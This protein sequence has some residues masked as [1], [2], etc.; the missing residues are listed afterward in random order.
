MGS[1]SARAGLNLVLEDVS[2][3]RLLRGTLPTRLS[4][5]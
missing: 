2:H 3:E 1:D 4:A 5:L